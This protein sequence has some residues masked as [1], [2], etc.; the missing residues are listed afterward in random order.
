MKKATLPLLFTGGLMGVEFESQGSHNF[1]GSNGDNWMSLLSN[2]FEEFQANWDKMLMNF[3]FWAGVAFFCICF[4]IWIGASIKTI[5]VNGI[6]SGK[7]SGIVLFPVVLVVDFFKWML[8]KLDILEEIPKTGVQSQ[9]V[10]V[11]NVMMNHQ[12]M[13]LEEVQDFWKATI[14]FDE[15]ML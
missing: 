13:Y 9:N 7:T 10:I 4:I 1:L 2:K 6:R 12:D 11:H 3:L 14:E 5:L 8:T 15:E